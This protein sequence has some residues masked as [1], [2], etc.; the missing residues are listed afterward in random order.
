MNN[1]RGGEKTHHQSSGLGGG[2]SI[3]QTNIN[4]EEPW[5]KASFKSGQAIG[6]KSSNKG[7]FHSNAKGRHVESTHLNSSYNKENA[8]VNRTTDNGKY[9]SNRRVGSNRGITPQPQRNAFYVNTPF[10]NPMSPDLNDRSGNNQFQNYYGFQSAIPNPENLPT[11]N[12]L[13]P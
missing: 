12:M 1:L 11:T 3:Q 13:K 6:Q 7:S 4:T 10:E 8:P 5:H 9:V 2:S